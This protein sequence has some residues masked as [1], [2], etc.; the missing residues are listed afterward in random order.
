MRPLILLTILLFAF[1]AHAQSA[2]TP[3]LQ[4]CD[5]YSSAEL[6]RGFEVL[7]QYQRRLDQLQTIMDRI[8]ELPT[9]GAAMRWVEWA[10]YGDYAVGQFGADV[11]ECIRYALALDTFESIV[12]HSYAAS[13]QLLVLIDT[14]MSS[15]QDMMTEL[16]RE[17][18]TSLTIEMSIWDI[19]YEALTAEQ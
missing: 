3:D 8:A 2:N 6:E 10:A 16:L 19:T 4:P 13:A 15:I 18:I 17:R 7:E 1:P 9:Q 5:L 12:S 14:D 11:P